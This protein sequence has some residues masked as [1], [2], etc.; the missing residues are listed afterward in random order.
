[1]WAS[2]AGGNGQWSVKF[3]PEEIVNGV[4]KL[5]VDGSLRRTID[6]ST[7]S[8]NGGKLNVDIA[9]A[10]NTRV[11]ILFE[12]ST[13]GQA[14]SVG[15]LRLKAR[16]VDAYVDKC[17]GVKNCLPSLGDGSDS[18]FHFRNSNTKQLACIAATTA[19]QRDA[20]SDHCKIFEACVSSSGITSELKALLGAAL[21]PRGSLA[22]STSNMQKLNDAEGC[23][24]PSVEDPESW[25]CECMGE[26]TAS[27]DGVDEACFSKIFC[28]NTNV[29]ESWKSAHCAEVLLA[30]HKIS[31]PASQNKSAALMR[32][33]ANTAIAIVDH[34]LDSALSGKCSQ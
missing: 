22:E 28:D 20:V 34:R 9:I 8:G 24:D 15:A 11:R 32:R 18:A 2:C 13:A 29:C 3:W 33:V 5:F 17:M 1:V 4:I 6:A 31:I 16:K 25:D 21:T 30:K 10:K 23:V 14:A 12:R 27:C 19:Q 26:M 7:P